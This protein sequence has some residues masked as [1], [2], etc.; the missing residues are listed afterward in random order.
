MLFFLGDAVDE[1]TMIPLFLWWLL[2]SVLGWLMWPIAA[3]IFRHAPGRGYAYAKVM[4][5]LLLSYIYWIL[6]LLGLSLNAPLVLWT[7]AALA[8]LAGLYAWLRNRIDLTS[9][10]RS[11]ARYVLSAEV[12]S[13]T[14][15]VL[16]VAQKSFDPAI[17]HTEQPMDFGFL[18]AV[19]RS[20][21][22]PPNDPWMA[23]FPVSY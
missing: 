1:E 23:G 4:G 22:M 6:G 18:N 15:F 5:L 3:A 12:V 14:V 11:E 10:L 9:F 17:A 16:C 7:V 20:V 21:H 13:L 8:A 2:L 19:L